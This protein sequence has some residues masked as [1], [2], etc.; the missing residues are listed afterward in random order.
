MMRKASCVLVLFFGCLVLTS[1]AVQGQNKER[2]IT[3]TSPAILALFRTVIAKCSDSTVLVKGDGK[4]LCLG[5]V[6]GEDGWILTKI[7]ELKGKLVCK[8]KDGKE[9][10][11]KVVGAHEPTDLALLKIEVK[12]LKPIEWTDSTVDPLG[13][14][15]A[16]PGLG[17]DPLAIGVVSVASRKMAGKAPPVRAAGGGYLGVS[18]DP[19]DAGAKVSSVLSG[20]PA[21]KAGVKVNDVILTVDKSK[22]G[23]SESLI[24]LLQKY[25]P[26]DVVALKVKRDDKEVELKATL[27]PRPSNRADFQNRLGSELS[28]RRSGFPVILQH[29]SVLRARDCGGALV[30]LEGRVIGINVSRAGRTETY[31]IPSEAIKPLIPDLKAGKFPPP[32]ELVQLSPEEKLNQAKAALQ[33]AETDHAAVAKKLVQARTALQKAEGDQGDIA[34]KLAELKTALQKLEAERIAIDKR[35]MEA[36]EAVEKAEAEAKKKTEPEKQ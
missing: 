10:E 15:V 33:K 29:D 13:A 19:D 36:N 25:K 27:A 34:K 21:E 30:D 9:L 35:L 22:V 6:V 31:A 20:T 32:K 24:Q 12:G 11:A 14:W 1:P 8:L 2:E 18:L 4:D 17:N 7:S 28:E 23:D 3:R 16:S 5:V 26:G